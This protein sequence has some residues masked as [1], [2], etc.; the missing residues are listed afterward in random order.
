MPLATAHAG[1]EDARLSP[2]GGTLWVVDT[3]VDAISAFAVNG[4]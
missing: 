4:G 2:G 3:G 1:A